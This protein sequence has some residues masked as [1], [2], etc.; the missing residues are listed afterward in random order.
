MTTVTGMNV[1]T[2]MRRSIMRT[3]PRHPGPTIQPHIATVIAPYAVITQRVWRHIQWLPMFLRRPPVLKLEQ[4]CITAPR[5]AGTPIHKRSLPE[6][7]L[8]MVFG[9]MTVTVQAPL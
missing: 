5:D 3:I 1:R 9:F 6:D 4:E 2:A 8:V 7:T